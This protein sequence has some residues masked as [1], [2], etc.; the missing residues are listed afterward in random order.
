MSPVIRESSRAGKVEVL[1]PN[2]EHLL[3]PGSFVRVEIEMEKHE[4]TTV[5]PFAA[6]TKRHG[7]Q[8]VFLVDM[9]RKKV[10][11]VPVET[12]IVTQEQVEIIKPEIQG[13]VVILGQH[14]LMDGSDIIIGDAE[15][16]LKGKKDSAHGESEK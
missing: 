6:L 2:H 4:N 5:V 11:F 9:E 14:M 16:P 13:Y 7:E 3:K 12:G 15:K 10:K 1:V 8:G